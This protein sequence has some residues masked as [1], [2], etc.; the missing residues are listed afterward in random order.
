MSSLNQPGRVK[1]CRQAQIEM[2]ASRALRST[3]R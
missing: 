3:S 1:W 2:P